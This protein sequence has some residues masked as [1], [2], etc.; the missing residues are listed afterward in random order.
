MVP[1][2]KVSVCCAARGTFNRSPASRLTYVSPDAKL[3]SLKSLRRMSSQTPHRHL[4]LDDF[5]ATGG[6]ARTQSTSAAGR[7]DLTLTLWNLV[8]IPSKPLSL[9]RITPLCDSGVTVLPRGDTT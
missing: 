2:D 4:S 5:Y 8:T 3:N 7:C 9:V 1:F 6:F